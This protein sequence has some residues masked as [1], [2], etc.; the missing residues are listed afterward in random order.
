MKA[1]HYEM[2]FIFDSLCTIGASPVAQLIKNLPAMQETPVQVLVQKI[3]WRSVR[4]PTPVFLGFP[5]GSVCKETT[6]NAGD[7]GLI[8]GWEGSPGE[9]N[10]NPL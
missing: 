7:S 1:R 9:R 8:P 6:C 4:L 5:G 10:D 3:P 2:F